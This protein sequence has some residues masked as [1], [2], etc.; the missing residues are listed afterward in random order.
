MFTSFLSVP[1]AF[2]PVDS[3]VSVEEGQKAD[4][5]C[6]VSGFPEP[7]I[8]WYFNGLSLMD[9]LASTF[10]HNSVTQDL[11]FRSELSCR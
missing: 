9:E 8:Q 2:E 5:S 3:V 7:T 1:I 6:K 10:L 4:I 11:H